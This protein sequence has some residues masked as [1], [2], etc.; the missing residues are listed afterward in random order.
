MI[1]L[2]VLSG[3]DYYEEFASAVRGAGFFLALVQ[4]RRRELRNTFAPQFI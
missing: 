1:S 3:P 4:W 2:N